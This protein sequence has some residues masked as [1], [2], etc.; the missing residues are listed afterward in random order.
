MIKPLK[1]SLKK[2]LKLTTFYQ[3]LRENRTTIILVMPLLKMEVV[4][5][6]DLE[7]LISLV[8]FQIYLKIFLEKVLEVEEEDL[9]D[10]IIEVRILDM[11]YQL[12]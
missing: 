11:T 7:I 1:T 8:T 5:E 3:T 12:L 4:E 6:E 10:L 2:H 9:E